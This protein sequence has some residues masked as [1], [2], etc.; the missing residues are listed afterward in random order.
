M[1]LEPLAATVPLKEQIAELRRE[2][3]LR[4]NAYSKWVR[5]GTLNA[6][7]AKKRIAALQAAIATLERLNEGSALGGALL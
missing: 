2:L 5:N 6:A 1:T 4:N 3:A 7:V